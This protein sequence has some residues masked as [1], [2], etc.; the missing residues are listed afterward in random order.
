M[1]NLV[2]TVVAAVSVSLPIS[3]F[4][5]PWLDRKNQRRIRK[6]AALEAAESEAARPVRCRVCQQ[7]FRLADTVESEIPPEYYGRAEPLRECVPCA[8]KR[9]QL[10]IG[11]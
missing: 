11:T 6:E 1:T 2:V 9:G 7:V 8:Q 4:L 5:H 3:L 10:S